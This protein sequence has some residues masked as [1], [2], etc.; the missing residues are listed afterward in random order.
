LLIEVPAGSLI[1]FDPHLVHGSQPNRS[2]LPRRA[3]V[4]TYQPA[5]FPMLKSGGYR[6]VS[7]ETV[8]GLTPP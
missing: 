1:F 6:H 7:A 2:P 3:I 8:S 4:L 5:G